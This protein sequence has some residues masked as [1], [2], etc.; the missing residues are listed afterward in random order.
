MPFIWYFMCVARDNCGKSKM[1]SYVVAGKEE[2]EEKEKM[3]L[4]THSRSLQN[5]V[6]LVQKEAL[7]N[8][9]RTTGIY[10]PACQS[11]SLVVVMAMRFCRRRWQWLH[12]C[13]LRIYVFYFVVWLVFVR[14]AFVGR[15]LLK[16]MYERLYVHTLRRKN[17]NLVFCFLL[18]CILTSWCL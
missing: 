14:V 16:M 11:A 10:L 1:C 15:R 5:Q 13:S 4:K 6:T 2:E 8:I 17:V 3:K 18:H 12:K 7:A 9:W